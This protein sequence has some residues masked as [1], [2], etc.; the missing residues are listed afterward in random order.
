MFHVFWYLGTFE[1][2]ETRFDYLQKFEIENL[3]H[4]YHCSYKN[5]YLRWKI[6]LFN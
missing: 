3:H 4:L 5:W 2:L 1:I 6:F